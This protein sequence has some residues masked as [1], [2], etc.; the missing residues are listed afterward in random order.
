MSVCLVCFSYFSCFHEQFWF[1]RYQKAAGHAVVN[2]N[3]GYI[4]LLKIWLLNQTSELGS[5]IRTF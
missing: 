5:Q 1:H 2:G 4:S 3:C